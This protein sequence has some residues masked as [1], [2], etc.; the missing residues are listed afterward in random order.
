MFTVLFPLSVNAAA[1]GEHIAPQTKTFVISPDDRE[2]DFMCQAGY[3]ESVLATATAENRV[4]SVILLD[5]N[6]NPIPDGAWA[7][8]SGFRLRR[9]WEVKVRVI[10][11]CGS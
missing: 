4:V 1:S 2:Q 5:E 6:K 8:A 10:M 11:V 3:L 9:K 7:S